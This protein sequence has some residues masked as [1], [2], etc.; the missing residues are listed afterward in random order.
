MSPTDTRDILGFVFSLTHDQEATPTVAPV[1]SYTALDNYE[2]DDTR[3]LSFPIGAVLTIIEKSEDGKRLSVRLTIA[4]NMGT[5]SLGW[6]LASYNNQSGWV[7]STY[8][9]PQSQDSSNNMEGQ[10]DTT[11]CCT[12]LPLFLPLSLSHTHT[13]NH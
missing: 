5:L 4:A 9:E 11:K 10:Y 1:L 13:Q 6:W 2:T 7:P 3:Q 12:S 8:L